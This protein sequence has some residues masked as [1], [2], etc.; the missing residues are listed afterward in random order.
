MIPGVICATCI[1]FSPP[2]GRSAVGQCRRSAPLLDQSSDRLRTV[3]P[4][5]QAENWC[6]DHSTIDSEA[7]HG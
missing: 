4:L 3:W 7:D 1:F 2:W 6:G 5:V